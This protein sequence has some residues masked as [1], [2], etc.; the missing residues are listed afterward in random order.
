M[1]TIVRPGFN[2]LNDLK[3]DDVLE[4]NK[5]QLEY[6]LVIGYN[7]DGALVVACSEASLEK[8]T[9][10]AERFKAAVHMGVYGNPIT[11]AP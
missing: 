11:V 4:G 8:A 3:P 7:K 9:Y 5:G 10:W 2:T 1:G 6:V